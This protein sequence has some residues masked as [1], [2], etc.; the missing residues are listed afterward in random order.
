MFLKLITEKINKIYFFRRTLWNMAVKQFK[1]KYA[2][3]V[4][5]V[6]WSIVNP[7]LMMM[8]ITF[9]F[10]VVF[11]TE[12][13]NF[14]L[15]VLSGILPWMFFS[16]A[17]SET[18]PSFIS[19]RGV[20]HQFSLPKE[21]L[22]LSITLSYFLTFLL[23]WCAIYPIFLFFN[24]KI[25]PLFPVLIV[26]LLF[27]YLFTSGISLLCSV[28]NIFF[29]D[30]EHLLGVLL[31]FWFWVTPVFYSIGMVPR[32]FRWIFKLNPVTPFIISYQDLIFQGKM[33][34]LATFGEIVFWTLLSLSSS[35]AVSI[36]FETR[37]LKRI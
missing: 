18:T 32:V 26:I 9:V 21:I 3:S 5:G 1:S 37:I 10:T 13:K 22:P 19:Q 27:T 15:F 31:M 34:A 17:I 2:G 35:L 29:R 11:K 30:I 12:I 24:P 20:L 8:A 7:L 33:P 14:G 36:C 25:A 23:S 16:G 6:F 28:A 4:L